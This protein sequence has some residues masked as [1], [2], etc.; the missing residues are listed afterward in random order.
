M[1]IIDIHGQSG[2]SQVLVG[3]SI[4]RLDKFIK[5]RRAVVITDRNVNQ[6]Y[7][8][9][10]NAYPLIEIG[11]GEAI[12]DLDTIREIYARFIDLEV[13]RS[14]V[15]V[16]IGGGIVTDISGFAASTFMRGLQFGYVATTL[17]A[18][19]DASVGGKTG[20]NFRGYKNMIG[21]F[22]Q[23]FFVISDLTLLKTLPQ[24][25]LCC[26]YCEAIKAALIGSAEYFAFLESHHRRALNLDE[27]IMEKL[28][29]DAVLLKKEI[30]QR[31]ELEKGERRTLN[32]GHTFGHALEKTTKMPHGEAVSIGITIATELSVEKGLLSAAEAERITRT[33]TRYHLP[34]TGSFDRNAVLDALKKDKKRADDIINF[35]LLDGIGKAVVKE[36]TFVELEGVLND[37]CEHRYR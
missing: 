16:G 33:L 32:F 15:I 27:K 21:V 23:P 9:H 20:V 12:K 13:D 11:T 26:G 8:H 22:S 24:K 7:N 25:E 6:Y 17:L 14:T 5:N 31:D 10:F 28:V 19:V 36:I 37:L 3:E 30:V 29:F 4:S 1:Q 2:D 34:V 35:V 18:Q